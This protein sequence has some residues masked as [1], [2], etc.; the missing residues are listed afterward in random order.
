M[1]T[2]WQVAG[3][4]ALVA[5]AI[6]LARWEGIPLGHEIAW[7]VFRSFVQLIALG[8]VIKWIFEAN[9]IAWVLPVLAVMIVFGAFTSR[10][11]APGV[12]HALPILLLAIGIG[13]AATIG[14]ALAVG[15]IH[16]TSR[17]LIPIGG[18]VIGQ[19][20]VSSGLSLSRLQ[21]ELGESSAQIEARLSLGATWRQAVDPILR[22]SISAGML[23]TIDSTKTAGLVAIPGTTVGMLLAGAA[24][25]DAVRLQLILFYL[26]VGSTSIV[27]VL[28]TTLAARGFFLTSAHQLRELGARARGAG[29]VARVPL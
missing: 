16:A 25:L 15:A 24:P 21:F 11:R 20:M 7:A 22:R 27:A 1:I 26:L 3:S 6:G 18:M 29:H 2:W 9:D 14:L 12:P 5:V 23:P 8:Y 17:A 13:T 19:G 28:A 10:G 4:L